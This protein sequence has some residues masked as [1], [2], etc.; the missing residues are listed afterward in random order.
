VHAPGYHSPSGPSPL[1]N[2]AFVYAMLTCVN[3]SPDRRRVHVRADGPGHHGTQFCVRLIHCS[4]T[5]SGQD[6]GKASGSANRLLSRTVTVLA[7]TRPGRRTPRPRP[8]EHPQACQPGHRLT[9]ANRPPRLPSSHPVRHAWQD[10]QGGI[11][12]RREYDLEGQATAAPGARRPVITQDL[13][14]PLAAHD[15]R[16]PAGQRRLRRGTARTKTESSGRGRF[17][18]ARGFGGPAALGPGS[19]RHR[20]RP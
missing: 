8:P 2:T 16:V 15:Q 11:R 19:T 20:D 7:A 17:R 10:V 6:L 13:L 9:A 1:T 3:I 14:P 18:D 12:N 5:Y 4:R